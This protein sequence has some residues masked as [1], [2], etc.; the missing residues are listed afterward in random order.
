MYISAL[1]NSVGRYSENCLASVPALKVLMVLV[2]YYLELHLIS[3][4]G[5]NYS[6]TSTRDDSATATKELPPKA[7]CGPCL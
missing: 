2:I 5:Q 6:M 3:K 7:L 4:L 1:Y